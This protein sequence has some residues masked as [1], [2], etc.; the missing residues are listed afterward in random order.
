MNENDK[1][2]VPTK[3]VGGGKFTKAANIN[4]QS[5]RN[6]SAVLTDLIVSRDLDLLAMTEVWH[7]SSEDVS[8]YVVSFLQVIVLS[9]LQGLQRTRMDQQRR[10]AEWL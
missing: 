5:A 2:S 9:I 4:A 10:V 7:E 3:C 6:K 8:P 1:H